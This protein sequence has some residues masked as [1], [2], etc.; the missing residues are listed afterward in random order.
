M[1]ELLQDFEHDT[2]PFPHAFTVWVLSFS[3]FIEW[4]SL[5]VKALKQDNECTNNQ[6]TDVRF[7]QC[8]FLQAHLRAPQTPLLALH[9]TS[10][11]Q[12]LPEAVSNLWGKGQWDSNIHSLTS[13]KHEIWNKRN[14]Y[15][16]LQRLPKTYSCWSSDYLHF[17]DN[18]SMSRFILCLAVPKHK[19]YLV[20]LGPQAL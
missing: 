2:I 8:P 17:P 14:N 4:G 9:S 15:F 19:F 13:L 11:L 7:A 16:F 6:P 12:R 20:F 3:F 18:Y 10:D 1:P 5:W